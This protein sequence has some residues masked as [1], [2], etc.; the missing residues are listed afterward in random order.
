LSHTA[1]AGQEAAAAFQQGVAAEPRLN[2]R[3]MVLRPSVLDGKRDQ[4]SFVLA[5]WEQFMKS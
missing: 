2:S 4:N 5:R 1:R 3:F